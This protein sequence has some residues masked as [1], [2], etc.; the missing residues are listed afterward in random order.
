MT[1]EEWKKV[2]KALKS[3]FS[4]GATLL[5]DGYEVT[6]VLMQKTQ[7]TNAIAVYINGE[8]KIK[9]LAEDCEERRRF[10]CCKRKTIIKEKD[11][12]NYGIRSKKA[13]QEFAD[14]YSYNEYSA[15][16]CNFA[17]LKKHLIK[18]NE[19]IELVDA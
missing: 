6:F 14:K 18:N 17:K 10:L 13:I 16:W 4:S 15:Y 2:D 7:F 8:F 9:W 19:N 5:I 1:A 3:V 12:K 11:Y